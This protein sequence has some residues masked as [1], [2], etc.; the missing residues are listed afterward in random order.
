MNTKH[1][2]STRWL[3]QAGCSVVRRS[4]C[5]EVAGGKA[6]LP[7]DRLHSVGAPR[8]RHGPFAPALG[9]LDVFTAGRDGRPDRVRSVRGATEDRHLGEGLGQDAL[10]TRAPLC[11]TSVAF[12]VDPSTKGIGCVCV[13]LA[14]G[15]A[16][17]H[18]TRVRREVHSVD[19][20][21]HQAHVGQASIKQVGLVHGNRCILLPTHNRAIAATSRCRH[22]RVNR[23]GGIFL[24][25]RTAFRGASDANNPLAKFL[26]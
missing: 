7:I 15:V 17:G 11:P 19:R 14:D 24:E 9:V 4:K 25:S 20:Q 21:R 22:D 18:H 5:V 3:A 1:R 26:R 8:Q 12:S 10:R 16:N 6:Q 13:F 23:S 2:P